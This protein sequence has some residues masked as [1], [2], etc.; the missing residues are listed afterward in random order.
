M[1]K[2]CYLYNKKT[3]S[4]VSCPS[5][6]VCVHPHVT[7]A[8]LVSHVLFLVFLNPQISGMIVLLVRLLFKVLS[9]LMILNS[10]NRQSLWIWIGFDIERHSSWTQYT[11]WKGWKR[12]YTTKYCRQRW[13]ICRIL[14]VDSWTEWHSCENYGQLWNATNVLCLH[15]NCKVFVQCIPWKHQNV[16]WN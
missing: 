15:G 7:L 14:Q 3:I 8:E 1:L 10:D 4:P 13:A 2:C 12:T 16:K 5:V 11:F 6:C 9:P